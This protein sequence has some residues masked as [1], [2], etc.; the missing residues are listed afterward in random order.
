MPPYL[1]LV[2]PSACWNAS[3]MIRCLS[4]RDADAGVGHREGDHRIGARR[5]ISLL[6]A[7][8]AGRRGRPRASRCPRSV[9]LKALESRFLSTCC[10]RL[11]SVSIAGGSVGVELD[12][13]TPAPCARPPGGSSA[14]RSRAARRSATALDV[15]RHRARLDLRQVEDVVDQRQQVGA[16]GVDGAARTRPASSVR[17]PS[18]FSDSSFDRISRLLSGVRSSCDMFAGTRTCTSR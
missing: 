14:R 3:K 8:A 15:D 18:A 5:A 12:A 17:L 16:G 4:R 9:N 13:R 2:V 10:R 7:P 1:R 11:A 6:A